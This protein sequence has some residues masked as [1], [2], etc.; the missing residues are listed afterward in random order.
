MVYQRFS[1]VKPWH[2]PRTLPHRLE[3]RRVST[4]V[5]FYLSGKEDE[6]TIIGVEMILYLKANSL[7]EY[8]DVK[9]VRRRVKRI[10][11]ERDDG[12]LRL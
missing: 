6:Q 3:R 1:F 5:R 8:A 10:L 12:T 9:T 7:K 4:W 2:A 11:R